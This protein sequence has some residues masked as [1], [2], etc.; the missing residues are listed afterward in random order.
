MTVSWPD[1]QM[2][3]VTVI[4]VSDM[5]EMKVTEFECETCETSDEW[6]DLCEM[7]GI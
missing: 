1:C 6:H 5:C 3:G 4:T 7:C 2:C